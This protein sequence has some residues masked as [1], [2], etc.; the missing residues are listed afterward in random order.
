MYSLARA[1]DE[2]LGVAR[3]DAEAARWM[4]L[5]IENGDYFALS[6]MRDNPSGWTSGFRKELQNRLREAGFYTGASDGAFGSGVQDAV[7]ALYNSKRAERE[8]ARTSLEQ[9]PDEMKRVRRYREEVE[10]GEPGSLSRLGW[11]YME[12]R[13]AKRDEAEAVRLFRQD[14][15]K[16]N[17]GAMYNL[18]WAYVYGR[19]VAQDNA[20]AARWIFAALEHG[21]A[22]TLMPDYPATWNID[23]R[24]ELQ[25]R[26]RDAGLYSGPNDGEFGPAVQAAVSA[27]EAR[28]KRQ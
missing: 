26:L 10:A 1:Y 21:Q 20:E 13:G 6:Q 9:D 22:L 3:D 19:G 25:N 15:D 8:R 24:K 7:R 16:G 14:V 17:S 23:F 2:G 11:M 12:G 28:K 5:A 18:G 27:L 4:F